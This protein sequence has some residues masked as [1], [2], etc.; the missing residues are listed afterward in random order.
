MANS[1]DPRHEQ[2][3]R[4]TIAQWNKSGQTIRDF[5]DTRQL[6][7]ASFYGWRREL[8]KRDRATSSALKFLPV[9]VRAEALLEIALP[10]GLVVRAPATV[11]PKAVAALVAALRT[12]PC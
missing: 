5:C 11:E 10:D 8:A 1:R 4:N 7:E 6:S 9:Q 2:F 3:W 12:T